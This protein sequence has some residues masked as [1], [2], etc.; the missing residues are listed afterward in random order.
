MCAWKGTRP[1]AVT[2]G[3]ELVF[4]YVEANGPVSRNAISAPPNPD[5]TGGLGLPKS[6]IYLSLDRL[7]KAGRAKRCVSPDSNELLWSTAVDAPCP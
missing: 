1:P 6:L 7:R 3:D 2:S 4:K 5:G